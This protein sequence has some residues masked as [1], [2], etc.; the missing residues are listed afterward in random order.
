MK[1]ARGFWKTGKKDSE[2][3]RYSPDLEEELRC[4]LQEMRHN[5][6]LFDLEVEP[7]LIEQ[8]IYEGEAL[9][10]RYEYLMRRARAVGLRCVL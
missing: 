9:R 5:K 2:Y 1:Q 4:C 10:C 3:Q 6:M 8:R 7:E